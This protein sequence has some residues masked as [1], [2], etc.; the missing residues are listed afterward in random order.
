MELCG[1]GAGMWPG[2]DVTDGIDKALAVPMPGPQVPG[3]Y[4]ERV[5]VE[6]S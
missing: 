6:A 2:S 4:P 5:D 3:V 1:I